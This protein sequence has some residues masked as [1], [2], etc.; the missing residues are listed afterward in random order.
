MLSGQ[1]WWRRFYRQDGTLCQFG[2]VLETLP[3]RRGQN[4]DAKRLAKE[5]NQNKGCCG[6][7]PNPRF[8]DV[9]GLDAPSSQKPYE[10]GALTD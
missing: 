10:S 2:L 5:S 6:W 3:W 9:P 8:P 7:D 4:R 1:L